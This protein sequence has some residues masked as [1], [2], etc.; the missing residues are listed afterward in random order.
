[1]RA[2]IFPRAGTVV[3]SPASG[4]PDVAQNGGK[5]TGRACPLCPGISDVSLLRYRERVVNL[6]AKVT[7]GA[8]DLRVPQQELN[9]P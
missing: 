4:C 6:D 1:M 3:K 9:S 8:L 2:A 5:R 7:D